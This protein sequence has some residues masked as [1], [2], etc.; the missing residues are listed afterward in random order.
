[1]LPGFLRSVGLG[2]VFFPRAHGTD[3]RRVYDGARP[4]DALGGI[5]LV[6]KRPVNA[7]PNARHLPSRRRRQQVIPEH[8]I[9]AGRYSQGMPACKTK[10]KPDSAVRC[11]T[12]LRPGKRLRRFLAGGKKGSISD[13][14]ASSKRGL[15]HDHS[16][17]SQPPMD[18]GSDCPLRR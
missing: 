2:S 13:Q 12:G 10:R 7:I 18:L 11:S 3:G 8:P 6:Q 15:R 5:Q 14:S 17:F 4:I 16:S 1:M 9:S